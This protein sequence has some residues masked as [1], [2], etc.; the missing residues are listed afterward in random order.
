ML[1]F[2]AISDSSPKREQYC[3]GPPRRGKAVM[4]IRGWGLVESLPE[5]PLQL[6]PAPGEIALQV[7]DS[8]LKMLLGS[9]VQLGSQSTRL[10]QR[11]SLQTFGAFA[12]DIVLMDPATTSGTHP[13]PGPVR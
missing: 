9:G 8:I 13:E 11:S 4:R 10:R 2:A 6:H 3:Q 5:M 1:S 7:L 12:A